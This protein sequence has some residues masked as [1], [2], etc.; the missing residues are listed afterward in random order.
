MTNAVTRTE[1][2]DTLEMMLRLIEGEDLDEKF[3]G[4]AEIVRD[5]IART[6]TE[7]VY[8]GTTCPNCGSVNIKGD[9]FDPQEGPRLAYSR[10]CNCGDCWATWFEE[11]TVTGYDGLT[12]W[13]DK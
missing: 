2:I 9:A 3:G 8:D 13:E 11:L 1:L 10:S 12:L 5:V 6:E 7:D 4:E